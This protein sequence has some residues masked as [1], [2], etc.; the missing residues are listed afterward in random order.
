ME[1][2]EKGK[3]EDPVTLFRDLKEM[4]QRGIITELDD[5]IASPLQILQ[6]N[7]MRDDV[8]YMRD[9]VINDQGDIEKVCFNGVKR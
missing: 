1:V 5:C 7:I 6:A 2:I 9:Y 8:D 4:E 3:K